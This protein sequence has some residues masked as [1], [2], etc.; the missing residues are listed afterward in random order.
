MQRP[1]LFFPASLA[2]LFKVPPPMQFSA[3]PEPIFL[4]RILAGTLPFAAEIQRAL[5]DPR[6]LLCVPQSKRPENPECTNRPCVY[7]TAMSSRARIDRR[8]AESF[9]G[10]T[11]D[12][13]DR[14]RRG[15]V[16]HAEAAAIV[17]T[18]AR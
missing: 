6:L 8:V 18:I 2:G 5:S 3:Y 4:L 14:K 16:F 1:R 12:V 9:H 17:L 11:V 13:T 15:P 7:G 10:E